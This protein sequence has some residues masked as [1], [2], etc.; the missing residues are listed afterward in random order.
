MKKKKVLVTGGAGFIGSHLCDRLCEE[1][2]GVY[3]VDNLSK[4]R[5]ENLNKNVDFFKININSPKFLKVLEALRPNII[6][7]LAA[8]SSISNSLKN[9]KKDFQT[10]LFSTLKLL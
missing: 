4:G 7:H 1:D 8:Q 3:V 2:F 6:F 5:I 9:P 10:N